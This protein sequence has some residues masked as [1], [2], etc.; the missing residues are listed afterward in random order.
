MRRAIPV[1]FIGLLALATS[2]CV[3]TRVGGN[4]HERTRRIDIHGEASASHTFRIQDRNFTRLD[5][6]FPRAEPFL[7]EGLARRQWLLGRAD[8]H[9]VVVTLR[10]LDG[11]GTVRRWRVPVDELDR[12]R[13]VA[14]RFD[15]RP[16]G[17]YEVSIQAPGLPRTAAAAV[18][19]TSD[20]RQ[21]GETRLDGR[22]VNQPLVIQT[23]IKLDFRQF[24]GT[25]LRRFGRDKPFMAAYFSLLLAIGG[26]LIWSRRLR[27][28]NP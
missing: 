25:I 20:E 28:T 26:L 12:P 16:P 13:T 21:G 10:S 3:E 8:G 15:E 17:R 6:F 23:Y 2:G 4:F 5:V 14:F 18:A 1:V 9:P 11:G 22:A 24:A 7:A 27:P 19:L